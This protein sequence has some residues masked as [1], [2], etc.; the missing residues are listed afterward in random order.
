MWITEKISKFVLLEEWMY[1][2]QQ[3][4]KE[5]AS[6]SNA[7]Y[8]FWLL[9]SQFY[10]SCHAIFVL[11]TCSIEHCEEHNNQIPLQATHLQDFNSVC[12]VID[13]LKE[14]QIIHLSDL[15]QIYFPTLEDT[16][17]ANALYWSEKLKI[18]WETVFWTNIIHINLQ[19]K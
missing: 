13:I 19:M 10:K 7:L 8:S 15:K 6:S 12:N 9:S 16:I 2:L 11:E 5:I 14:K 1:N 3:K 4:R 18:N 17:F